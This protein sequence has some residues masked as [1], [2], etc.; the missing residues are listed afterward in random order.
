VNND[1][2]N[3]KKSHHL[4]IN[5]GMDWNTSSITSF[6]VFIYPTENLRNI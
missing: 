6:I 2:H 1:I 3:V 5:A 4:D